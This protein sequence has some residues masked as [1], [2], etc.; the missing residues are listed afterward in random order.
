MAIS[1][2]R[3]RVGANVKSH[4]EDLPERPLFPASSLLIETGNSFAVEEVTQSCLHTRSTLYTWLQGGWPA[5]RREFEN[6]AP[7]R[8]LVTVTT[9]AKSTLV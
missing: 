3:W 5:Q 9:K 6:G 4:S 1:I 8:S 7:H 2:S